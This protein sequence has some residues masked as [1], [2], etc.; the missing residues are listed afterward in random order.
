MAKKASKPASSSPRS[1]KPAAKAPGKSV[2]KAPPKASRGTAT[3]QPQGVTTTPAVATRVKFTLFNFLAQERAYYVVDRVPRER[4]A[5]DVPE[6]SLAHSIVIID[7]S[8]SMYRDLEP[9][10][11][12]LV[13]LLTLE[14]YNRF[15]MVV[16]LLSYASQGDLQCHFQRAPIQEIMKRDSRYLKE[17][18]KI[19]VSGATCISQSLKLASSLAK[20]EEL[21]GITLHSD[22]YANDPSPNAEANAL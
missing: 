10:K 9:L 6:K 13:K 4:A 5:E 19:R 1:R 17:I 3:P 18:E 15:E 22:G 14:E 7:R 21:T 11:E 20:G 16:T 2:S 12:T 8:G